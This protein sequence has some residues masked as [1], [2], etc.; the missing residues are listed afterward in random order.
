MF[1]IH[2]GEIPY[3]VNWQLCFEYSVAQVVMINEIPIFSNSTLLQIIKRLCETFYC[4][5]ESS[6]AGKSL[7]TVANLL[8]LPPIRSSPTYAS[9]NSENV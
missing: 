8:Q 6:F 5:V 2:L 1:E 3:S 9:Q 7:L 4:S